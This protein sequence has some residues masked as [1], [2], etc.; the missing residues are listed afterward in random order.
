MVLMCARI[1]LVLPAGLTFWARR[2][3]VTTLESCPEWDGSITRGSAKMWLVPF[4]FSFF[5][6]VYFWL[7]WVFVAGRAFLQ[8]QAQGPL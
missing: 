5:S 8:L 6:F 7:F 1:R 4:F 2:R 3:S